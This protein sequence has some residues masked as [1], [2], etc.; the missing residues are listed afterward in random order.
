[1]HRPLCKGGVM[2]DLPVSPAFLSQPGLLLVIWKPQAGVPGPVLPRC[3]C[4]V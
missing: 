3:D 1:M 2:W 4:G